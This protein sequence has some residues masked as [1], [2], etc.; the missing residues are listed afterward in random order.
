MRSVHLFVDLAGPDLAILSRLESHCEANSQGFVWIY[1][2]LPPFIH[3]PSRSAPASKDQ[4]ISIEGI[5]TERKDLG[6]WR[7]GSVKES[8]EISPGKEGDLTYGREES[9]TGDL[10]FSHWASLPH[11]RPEQQSGGR[12]VSFAQFCST[13]ALTVVAE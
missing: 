1:Q 4:Q 8:N 12:G 3:H 6:S 9:G 2:G 5:L 10:C 13:H 11:G 7:R